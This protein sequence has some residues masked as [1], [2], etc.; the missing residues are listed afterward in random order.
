M[1][2]TPSP[3]YRIRSLGCCSLGL[4][5]SFATQAAIQITP[6]V[7]SYGKDTA[8]TLHLE[9]GQTLREATLGPG[10]PQSLQKVL[11][12]APAR[13]I[14]QS[15]QFLLIG[16]DD[17]LHVFDITSNTLIG[18]IIHN[19][20]FK[21]ILARD[22][23]TLALDNN[24]ILS[25]IDLSTPA[26]PR[27]VTQLKSDETITRIGKSNS[28]YFAII[29]GS[30]LARVVIAHQDSLS[31]EALAT[32]TTTL[33]DITG[34]G[35][36]VYL[37]DDQGLSV[38]KIEGN[39]LRIVGRQYCNSPATSVAVNND[40]AL[41]NCNGIT[42][43]DVADPGAP[44]WLG[45]HQQLGNVLQILNDAGQ[46]LA[47]TDNGL[48]FRLTIDNPLEPSIMNSWRSDGALR[49]VIDHG[50]KIYTLTA[51]AIELIDTAPSV[52]QLSNEALNFGQGVNL[53]GE[54]RV[55]VSGH[56]AYVADWFSGIHIYDIQQPEKPALLSSLH[57]PGSPKGIVV[58]DN[59][60]YVADD[61]HGLQIIDVRDPGKPKQITSLATSGLAYTPKLSG[62]YLYLASHRGGFQIIDISNAQSPR[63]ITDYDTPGKAWSLEVRD[64]RLYVADDDSGLLI[65]D[66]ADLTHPQLIGQ[67]SP[68]G[69]AEEVVIRDNIAF[70]A[71]FN[72]GLYIL[73]ISEP[74]QPN[75]IS[76]LGLPGNARGLDVIGNR[77]YIASWLAGIQIVD[78][79]KL[80]R[81]QLI[82]AID[83]PG[84][85]WGV[86]VHN[87]YALVMDWWGGFSVIDI[88]DPRQLRVAGSYHRRGHV[89]N[90]KTRGNY[91]FS[92]EGNHG[93]QV[94][95]I[96]N[97]LNPTWITGADFAGYAYDL[98]LS[99][100]EILV[101]AGHEGI[102]RIEASDPFNVRVQESLRG[103]IDVRQMASCNNIIF[104]L[105]QGHTLLALDRT[106]PGKLQ[107]LDRLDIAASKFWMLG[108]QLLVAIDNGL[109]LI[110]FDQARGFG[111]VT[112]LSA[113]AQYDHVLSLDQNK[114]FVSAR[115]R[116]LQLHSI[117]DAQPTLLNELDAAG[118]VRALSY[119]AN[120][121]YVATDT[122]LALYRLD[123]NQLVKIARYPLLTAP[124]SITLNNG[125]AYLGGGETPIAIRLLA[126][127]MASNSGDA[128]AEVMIPGSLPMGS[129][130]LQLRFDNDSSTTL[131]NGLRVVMPAFGKP[132]M[133]LDQFKLLLEQKKGTDLFVQPSKP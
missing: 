49:G 125:T 109:A 7:V 70:V 97:P 13:S 57:T 94:F 133:T 58:R 122:E 48:L 11:L 14:T 60:A 76:H 85:S 83:T 127:L 119:D 39:T 19:G 110:D 104:A 41:I 40:L 112:H 68:G 27:I 65:F 6:E 120:I 51:D 101:A 18:Q 1:L 53:G 37:A 102:L 121:L 128:T 61:D 124:Q 22:T 89:Q 32:T 78:I 75:V 88:R 20:G 43:V 23:E 116:R 59:I 24:N 114:L 107:I 52:P 91:L 66:I 30:K 67:F 26:Q 74:T 93:L 108:T 31:L 105:D 28:D 86:K 46:P 103:L 16:A 84:A 64:D 8:V 115:G 17:G 98:T 106:Q 63:L 38:G 5:L 129:Y 130:D 9:P 42:V 126:T 2:K 4:L 15:G 79:S 35:D 69:A 81:P 99:H 132:K 123:A 56:L 36:H 62:D 90:S 47:L 100:N 113:N 92:A 54:R 87:N 72:D 21:Q 25:L 118:D 73:D 82:G 12:P 3:D 111:A 131:N 29:D 10:G 55:F 117:A 44:R 77:V 96:K 71:F 45:S 50:D 80:D 34:D 33:H 95:D